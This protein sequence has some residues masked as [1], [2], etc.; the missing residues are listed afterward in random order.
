MWVGKGRIGAVWGRE[1]QGCDE[2]ERLFLGQR[3]AR[4][5]CTP[6]ITLIAALC[7]EA[8]GLKTSR[9]QRSDCLVHFICIA[10]TYL[11]TATA[12]TIQRI[13]SI[14]NIGRFL[15]AAAT[16]DVTFRR[17]N[18][19]FAEN[20]RG[21]TT[22]CAIL[23][24]LLS[25]EPA[26][27][28]GRATLGQPGA[29]QAVIRLDGSNATFAH[30]RWD[31]T[32]PQLAI[33]DSTYV[34]DNVYAGETVATDQR[35]SLY[36]TI[37]GSEGVAL[38]RR[39]EELDGQIRSKNTEIRE[40]RAEVQRHVP[41]SVTLD[42]FLAFPEDPAIDEKITAKEQEL[43]AVRQAARIRDRQAFR[44]I[45]LPRLPDGIPELLART[46]EGVAA[47]AER[48]VN[49]HVAAHRMR[50]NG[51]R[52]LAEGLPYIQDDDTCP[53]CGQGLEDISLIAAYKAY[54]SDTYNALRSETTAMIAAVEEAIGDAS[55]ALVDRTLE[56]NE[57]TAE[58]WEQY[59]DFIRPVLPDRESTAAVLR[60]L[61][62]AALALLRR[63]A[64]APLEP[65]V[66]DND[67]SEAS[68]SY[69]TLADAVG[70]YNERVT[71]ANTRI[72][73]KKQQTESANTQQVQNELTR[74]VA[75]KTRHMTAVQA[76]CAAYSARLTEKTTLDSQKALTR[77][78]LDAHTA[79][80]IERYAQSI[81]TYLERINAGFTIT[82][83]RHSYQGGVPSTS[84]QIVINDVAID[85]GDADTPLDQPSF[86]NT[87][88]AGDRSTLALAFFLAE[89]EHDPDRASKI[90]VFDDPFSSQD[91]FRRNHTAYQLKKCGEH[92]AQIFVLS[93]DPF[94]LKH[95]WDKLPTAGRKALQLGRVGERNT[96]IGEWD[97]ERAVQ[98]QY[99]AF[100]AVL[101]A[102]H[103][104][105]EGDPRDVIQKIRPVL[106]GYCRNLFPTQFSDAD[107][108]GDMIARI[109]GGG[110][111]HPLADVLEHL[112]ELNE[113]CRRY[114]HAENPGGAA[115]E[116]IDDAELQN[117]VKRTLVV[118][119]CIT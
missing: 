95:V 6:R 25:G 44:A 115:T 34:S 87:L 106:E 27:I 59:C 118:A 94:F 11:L 88:S 105:R 33:F 69:Q 92:C 107:M 77:E 31:R 56:Q 14:K 91:S 58:F 75:Q 79:R 42:D 2:R 7:Y 55:I 20:G 49:Q 108:L 57:T 73:A 5:C 66:P 93:H 29:P 13:I 50:R 54:F 1:R 103:A 72:A 22:L 98:A 81:K 90:V 46:L 67:F 43:A 23:R 82:T 26:H 101:H 99:R 28:R 96:S 116:T 117:Y 37:I 48:Q 18:L 64:G 110:D 24:S 41:A 68:N 35:R 100:L 10:A 19:I 84:Y 85:L 17:Y 71:A 113:Y 63:K 39:M 40:A 114:H 111:A 38:A 74:L 30:D 83:P 78:D 4:E 45:D 70:G 12:M 97:I 9:L 15:N 52:W 62:D 104:G 61:R 119:G 65:V 76:D 47:D 53:F 16:G 36:R 8:G 102:Y 60:S 32:L 112:Q 86:R 3:C 80:V 89:L 51:E 109:R 21:K